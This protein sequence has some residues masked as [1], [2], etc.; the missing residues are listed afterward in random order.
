MRKFFNF[1]HNQQIALRSFIGAGISLDKDGVI[2][3]D[4]LYFVGGANSIR[5]WRQRTLGQGSYNNADDNVDKLGEV[6]IEV[7]AEYRFPIT[8]ILK[9]AL[10]MDAGNVWTE[11]PDRDTEPYGYKNIDINRFYKEFAVSPG[12]GLRLDFDFFLFRVDLGVPLKQAYNYSTWKLES[13]KTQI[14]FGVGYPF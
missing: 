11:K 3:F 14:N 5:G 4:Q 6:K 12:L 2:P 8:T 9:G 1:P 10:F 13:N 7:N